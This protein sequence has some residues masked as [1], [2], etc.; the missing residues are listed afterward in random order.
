MASDHFRTESTIPT[1]VPP[2]ILAIA[3]P[4]CEE[5]LS[6][7]LSRHGSPAFPVVPPTRIPTMNRLAALFAIG[8]FAAVLSAADVYVY[9]NRADRPPAKEWNLTAGKASVEQ[10]PWPNGESGL[11]AKFTYQ[12]DP[13]GWPS[14]K[15]YFPEGLRDWSNAKTLTIQ[16][17][18]EK[19]GRVNICLATYNDPKT[20]NLGEGDYLQFEPGRHTIVI[21]L[22]VVKGF[23][24]SQVKYLDFFASRPQESY[25]LYVGDITLQ[26]LSEE[27]EAANRAAALQEVVRGFQWR[28]KALDNKIPPSA[29]TLQ[30]ALQKISRSRQNTWDEVKYLQKQAASIFPRLDSAIFRNEAALHNGLAALWCAPEEKVL[31][32]GYAFYNAPGHEYTLDAARG[33]GESAQLVAFALE[34]LPGVSV[35]VLQ[36]PARE[37]G[38]LLPAEALKVSPVGYVKVSNPEYTMEHLGYWPDPILEYLQKP[39]DLE[40]ETFQSWWLDVQVPEEQKPGLYRGSLQISDDNGRDILM[41]FAVRV[42]DFTLKPGVPYFSPCC[43]PYQS[44]LQSYIANPR[45]YWKDIASMLIQHRLDP[46]EIYYGMDRSFLVDNSKWLL[47]HG[48]TGFNMGYVNWEVDDAF[49]AQVADAYK[50]CKEAGILDKAYI[51]C[52]DES[53]ASKFDMIRRSLKRV[54]EVAPGIPLWTTLYDASFGEVSDLDEVIDGWIPLNASYDRNADAVLRARARGDKVAWYVCCAP[55]S[56]FANVLL[57]LPAAGNRLLMG[58][59]AR[60]YSIDGFLYYSTCRWLE[61]LPDGKTTPIPVPVDGDSTLLP[62]PWK[63]ESFRNFPGDGRLI[64]PGKDAPLPT[65]RLKSMRDGM[66]DWMYLD[67][68]EKA[69]ADSGSMPADWRERARQELQVEDSLVKNVADWSRDPA[70]IQAKKLRIAAL[71]DEYTQAN[72]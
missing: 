52:Y 23:D 66:E 32:N 57:D 59:M 46:A 12:A 63:G 69:L 28:A 40:K 6:L 34:E 56:P 43:L 37:D 24:L 44:S 53:P 71:L 35:K 4:P 25:S 51:Y 62:E 18:C 9:E 58:F 3:C 20:K 8:L 65:T 49:A 36:Q 67:L 41:P 2:V 38:V 68:L 45:Q 26:I 55:T 1:G 39:V 19:Q 33:E 72:P 13:D 16:V 11:T 60:K 42:H 29:R 50:R 14:A 48:A 54:R 10:T 7:P 70:P 64:Y 61:T 47:E 30:A 15:L 5:A 17:Y 27:E 31:R 21:D 22:N